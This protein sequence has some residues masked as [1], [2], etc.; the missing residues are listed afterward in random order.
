MK[1][2][3]LLSSSLSTSITLSTAVFSYVPGENGIETET[4]GE[5]DHTYILPNS[6]AFL[7]ENALDILSS[8]VEKCRMEDRKHAVYVQVPYHQIYLCD[9]LHKAGF[10]YDTNWFVP[11]EGKE[12]RQDIGQQ[13]IIRHES[14]VPAQASFTHTARVILFDR[15]KNVLQVQKGAIK[16]FPGGISDPGE[17]S[18][19]TAIREVEE[20]V[21]IKIQKEKLFVVET[22][23]RQAKSDS[24]GPKA[25]GDT[26][27]YYG[28]AIENKD[29]LGPLTL[30][31]EEI[32][33]AGWRHYEEILADKKGTGEH[34]RLALNA[35]FKGSENNTSFSFQVP[36]FHIQSRPEKKL[37]ASKIWNETMHV[38]IAKM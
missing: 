6:S 31:V 10:K 2:F 8:F 33:W 35:I 34:I 12:E 37:E 14:S 3:K 15:E 23:E 24:C 38:T 25:A 1:F 19:L 4:Q 7:E 29:E 26:I 22:I 27:F 30:Q 11:V 5:Y 21:G 17:P 18:V 36:D 20:E 32:K 13:W 16:T 28:Y 9:L